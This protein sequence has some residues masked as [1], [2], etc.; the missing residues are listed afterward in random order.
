MSLLKRHSPSRPHGPRD[1]FASANLFG[2]NRPS[3][4]TSPFN[5][6]ELGDRSRPSA[7]PTEML[8]FPEKKPV[9]KGAGRGAG[10]SS[11]SKP[12]ETPQR[13]PRTPASVTPSPK[14]KQPSP[15]TP[16]KLDLPM[17]VARKRAAAGS[18]AADKY[19][20]ALMGPPLKKSK[21]RKW[22]SEQRGIALMHVPIGAFAEARE[23]SKGKRVRMPVLEYWRGESVQYERK[24]GSVAP[25]VCGVILNCAPRM[26]DMGDRKMLLPGVELDFQSLEHEA[27]ILGAE[28]EKI[29]TRTVV[30]PASRS[31]D[32]PTFSMAPGSSGMAIVVDGAARCGEEESEEI[33]LLQTGDTIQADH[34]MLF[35]ARGADPC[36]LKVMEA[37]KHSKQELHALDD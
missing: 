28:T 19:S 30:L 18:E 31:K 24:P 9:G 15:S 22:Q 14:K 3:A 11:K 2:R 17:S 27:V 7:S 34:R 37:K 6:R 12:P 26:D 25:T 4:S 29:C 32:P 21:T 1:V 35:A 20:I 36:V 33:I 8:E 13:K 10:S 5:I 23:T 16:P